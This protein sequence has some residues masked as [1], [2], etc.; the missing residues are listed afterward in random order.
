MEKHNHLLPWSN[1]QELIQPL[2]AF[3][4]IMA[5]D[6][7]FDFLSYDKYEDEK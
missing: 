4:T 3:E 1:D 6:T 7:S 2:D 5:G